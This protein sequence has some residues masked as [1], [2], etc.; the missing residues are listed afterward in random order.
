[1]RWSGRH[2]ERV[3]PM[4]HQRS[5]GDL[6]RAQFLAERAFTT[7]LRF[8]HVDAVN[9]VVLRIAATA[10]L[11]WANSPF[12]RSYYALWHLSFSIGLGEFVIS[13]PLHFW[14]NKAVMTVFFLVVGME[15][16]REIDEGALSEPDQ[17]ILPVAAAAGGV[18]APALIYL[19]LNTDPVRG[20]GWAVP[21]AA[22]IAF[23]GGL[24]LL[25]RSIPINVRVFL[26]ALAIIDDVIAVLMF[27][28]VGNGFRFAGS[29]TGCLQIA[30]SVRN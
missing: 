2:A 12:A 30:T 22:D 14:I 1:M 6:P 8:S 5:A 27:G 7:L 15:I 4:G 3:R 26:L 9:S 18:I 16:R 25:G 24:A 28:H 19:S 11:I 23:A 10:A 17:A 20:Q 21:T 13:R 29:S